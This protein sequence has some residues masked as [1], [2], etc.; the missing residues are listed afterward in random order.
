M[1]IRRLELVGF[2]SFVSRTRFE[3]PD[4]ITAIVGPNGCGKSNIVDAIRWVLGEQSPSHLRGRAMEDVIFSGNE[5]TGPLGMAEVSLT[6]ERP[7]LGSVWS[8]AGEDGEEHSDLLRQLAGVSEITVTRRYFRSGDSEFFINRSPC[9]LRDITELF[10]GSGVGTKAYA[11][12]EQGRVEQLV[13][14][15]PET[16]RLFIEEAAGTTRYRGRKGM[17]ERKLERTR[18]NLV[19]LAD[20]VREIERQINTVTRQ[21]KRAEEYRQCREELRRLELRLARS[22]YDELE[23][24]RVAAEGRLDPL[25]AEEKRLGDLL[26]RAEAAALEA[27][28]RAREAEERQRA[29]EVRLAERRVETEARRARVEYLDEALRGTGQRRGDIEEERRRLSVEL[30]RISCERRA[31]EEEDCTLEATGQDADRRRQ[32]LEGELAEEER[33]LEGAEARL[34]EAKGAALHA[35]AETM[36]IENGLDALRRRRADVETRLGHARGLHDDLASARTACAERL[37]AAR[38]QAATLAEALSHEERAC[39]DAAGGVEEA[40]RRESVAAGEVEVGRERAAAIRSRLASLEELAARVD[41]CGRSLGDVVPAIGEGMLGTVADVLRVPAEYETAVAAVLG[42][43][44]QC[45][46]TRDH[47]DAA[48]ALDAVEGSGAG[49]AS[50][51]PLEPR[52]VLDA[53]PLRRQTLYD[54]VEVAEQFRPL[55]RSLLGGV[56]VVDDL[57]QALT[58]WRRNG[59]PA[60]F[61]TRTGR[62][63]DAAGV[64]TGGS[65]PPAEETLLARKREIGELRGLAAA[66]TARLET[67]VRAQTDA[68]RALEDAQRAHVTRLGQAQAL[69]VEHARALKDEERLQEDERRLRIEWEAAGAGIHQLERE[70]SE[71]AREFDETRALVGTAAAARNRE[72]ASLEAARGVLAQVRAAAHAARAA[73]TE[74]AIED[75]RRRAI[76]EQAAETS[77]RTAA[78]AEVIRQRLCD[79]DTRLAQLSAEEGHLLAQR[80]ATRAEHAGRMDGLTAA[81]AEKAAA[82]AEVSAARAALAGAEA[83]VREARAALQGCRDQRPPI[84]VRLAELGATLAH[85]VAAI[86]EKYDVDPSVPMTEESESGPLSEEERERI[87]HLRNRMAQIGE[88]HAGAIEELDELRARHDF[89]TR[90]RDDLQRSVDDLRRTI[91]KLN[92]LSKG[93]FQE[94]FDEANAKLQQVFPRLFPGGRARLLLAEPEEGEE[95]GVEIVVQPAGKKLQALTL[96]SGGEKALT[97][98]SLI[99]SLFMIRPAPFCILDEVDAP[100]DDVNVGRFDHVVREISRSSQFVVITHNKRT[101][102]AADTLYG[103]TMEEP[104][105]S[106]VVSVRFK[107]K[108]AA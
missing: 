6:L 79:L 4:G 28:G 88:V 33:R 74:L 12:I 59:T 98:V 18:E 65:E 34:E 27:R 57:G 48:R 96:L 26:E 9:R 17:A 20:V 36:R 2:K 70:A 99:L 61:V 39:G 56:V 63:L 107:E 80:D 24:E 40:R 46:I 75:A 104:G 73:L 86:R 13:N 68:A 93:R 91:A 5:R 76:R 19:R 81:E 45:I 89:L 66:A 97:A 103:I 60:A 11:I 25:S 3:F 21:A 72:E 32:A 23:A 106:R 50:F 51:V 87:D 108:Q 1:H 37:A 69:R 55:A 15:K 54:F 31:A 100:L 105:V 102:E 84:E 49:R 90:Q 38:R 16:L 44:L 52:A 35:L 29:L 10:L 58:E 101:M 62:V 71:V 14:A 78:R 22:R 8:D 83:E 41:G 53:T 30:E 82:A 7:G 94:T 47:R 67:A 92:R 42:S 64:L 95:P 43:R 77:R 85:L